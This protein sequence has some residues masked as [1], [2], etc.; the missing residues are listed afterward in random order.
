MKGKIEQYPVYTVTQDSKVIQE[1]IN[2]TD[3]TRDGRSLARA[4]ELY[5][6][7]LED[8]SQSTRS[9]DELFSRS[10]CCNSCSYFLGVN[11][12]P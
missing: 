10:C 6:I 4:F 2:L 12:H 7:K 11:H 8:G 1:E 5:D 9:I 3:V